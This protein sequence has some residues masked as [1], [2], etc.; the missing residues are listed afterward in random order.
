MEYS[1]YLPCTMTSCLF[2]EGLH[3]LSSFSVT[4]RNYRYVRYFCVIMVLCNFC[5]TLCITVCYS[6]GST[7]SNTV[8]PRQTKI[9]HSGITFVSRNFSLFRT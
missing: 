3:I 4:K 1:D 2:P 5:D 6:R 7:L 8:I 9:I